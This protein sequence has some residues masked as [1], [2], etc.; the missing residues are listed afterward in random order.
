MANTSIKL[1]GGISAED[2][3][4]L[5]RDFRCEPRDLLSL[6]EHT[7][8]CFIRGRNKPVALD[9]GPSP[10]THV[11]RMTDQEYR[12][13]RTTNR[14]RL[15]SQPRDVEAEPATTVSILSEV[16]NSEPQLPD[17]SEASTEWR[18]RID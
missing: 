9:D 7:W 4:A 5:A 18:P 10:L 2:A 17:A 12:E 15:R 13:F 11:P 3:N 16:E 1:A 14:D 6:K 8:A